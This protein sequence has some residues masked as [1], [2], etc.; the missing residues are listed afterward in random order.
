LLQNGYIAEFLDN[1]FKENGESKAKAE[2]AIKS[3]NIEELAS[4]GLSD[5]ISIII[6]GRK[7]AATNI[8]KKINESIGKGPSSYISEADT[9]LWSE[10]TLFNLTSTGIL[11]TITNQDDKFLGYKVNINKNNIEDYL[12]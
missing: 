9:S 12:K 7:D 6:N 1:I 3:G 8:Y 10:D 5:F 2:A 4:L 11:S